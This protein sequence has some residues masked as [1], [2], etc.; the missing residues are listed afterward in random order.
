MPMD[1]SLAPFNHIL[2]TLCMCGT[3]AVP[4]AIPRSLLSQGVNSHRFSPLSP[5]EGNL[6]DLR[7]WWRSPLQL[8]FI[9]GRRDMYAVRRG[10][11]V[12]LRSTG[13]FLHASPRWR[14][15]C[16]GIKLDEVWW[17]EGLVKDFKRVLYWMMVL[18]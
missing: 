5:L 13:R 11:W 12:S 18:E 8:H 16:K 17:M 7:W 10:F 9:I 14:L 4:N 3:L 1:L 6:L 2:R 15:Y